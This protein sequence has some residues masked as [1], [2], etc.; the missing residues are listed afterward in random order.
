MTD[1]INQ[2]RKKG[3]SKIAT[4]NYGLDEITGGGLPAGRPTL[5]CGGAGSGKTLMAME[6]LVKGVL[7]FDQNGVFLTF[8]ESREE[9]HDNFASFGFDINE[10]EQSGRIAVRIIDPDRQEHVEVGNYSL[11][12]LF[13]QLELAIDVVRARRVVID[14]IENLFSIFS[15]QAVIRKE[16]KRLFKW[17]KQKGVTSIITLEKGSRPGSLTRHGFEEYISDCV[18]F[19]DHRMEGQIATRRLRI[20]KYRGTS[21]GTNEYPFLITDKGISVFPVTSLALDHNAPVERVTTGNEQLDDLFGGQGYYR[22]SS[23][24]ISGTAG[25]G[26][27]SFAACFAK[28][29]CDG[30]H[31]C[32]YFAF[33]ESERQIIRNM[34][35]TGSS[36][37]AHVRQGL[38]KIHA[39]RPMLLGLEMHLLSMHDMIR[40]FNPAAVILDPISNLEAIGEHLDIKLMFIRL[41]DYLKRNNITALFTCLT[42]GNGMEEST[43]VGISSVM[44]TWI[45]LR[46]HLREHRRERSLYIMKSRGMHHSSDIHAFDITDQGIRINPVS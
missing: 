34:G 25:T 29:V 12:G 46:H 13:S 33:E 9:L 39:V 38:L 40:D 30:G 42:P 19:L 35:R 22:G 5:L 4:G 11:S 27:S 14:G 28:A 16:I 44:D 41:F 24:L 17:L 43:E 31:R 26:K 23:V 2:N 20:V 10:L 15:R 6:F 7:D 18:I 21:H 32:I 8:E 3:L 36:L 37:E 45:L 1:K